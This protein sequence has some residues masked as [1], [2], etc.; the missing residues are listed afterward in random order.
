[1]R[2]FDQFHKTTLGYAVFGLIELGAAYGFGLWAIDNG[3]VWLYFI[4]IIFFGGGVQDIAKLV[5][6]ALND[7][8]R[9]TR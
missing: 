1:M 6:R 3:N 8:T 4:T 7:K 9:R 2:T 5:G